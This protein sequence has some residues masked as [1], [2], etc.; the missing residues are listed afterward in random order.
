LADNRQ[1][2]VAELKRD[3]KNLDSWDFYSTWNK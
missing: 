2:A 1:R 3:H